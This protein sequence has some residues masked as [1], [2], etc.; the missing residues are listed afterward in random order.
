MKAIRLVL[1]HNFLFKYLIVCIRAPVLYL[2]RFLQVANKLYPLS[3]ISRQI[4]EFAKETLFSVMSDA[5]EATDAEG[6]V[7]D[8]QKVFM[9]NVFMNVIIFSD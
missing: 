2:R 8:S 1:K 7:A 4:E 6:S 9:S 3:S 5:S